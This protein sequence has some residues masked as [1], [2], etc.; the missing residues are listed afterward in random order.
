MTEIL[1]RLIPGRRDRRL[2]RQRIG[3]APGP[4]LRDRFGARAMIGFRAL[5]ALGVISSVVRG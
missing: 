4:S 2:I 3:I 5:I 1:D